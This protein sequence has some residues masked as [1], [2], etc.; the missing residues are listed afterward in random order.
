MAH[1]DVLGP[2]IVA[3]LMGIGSMCVYIWGVMSAA[4][5]HGDDPAVQFYLAEMAD[6]Q[7]RKHGRGE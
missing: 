2:Y 5:G 6:E 3:L 1:F 4:F 7:A